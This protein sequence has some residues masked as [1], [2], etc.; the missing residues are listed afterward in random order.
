MKHLK[1]TIKEVI[2]IRC[3]IDQ[4]LCCQPNS[5]IISDMSLDDLFIPINLIAHFKDAVAF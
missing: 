2:D 5:I 4:N 3:V 1:K